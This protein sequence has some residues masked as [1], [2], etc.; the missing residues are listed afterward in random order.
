MGF[1]G[2]ASDKGPAC[3]CRDLR[4]SDLPEEVV[5]FLLGESHGQRKL[6]GCGP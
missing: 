6:A 1:P 3:Q 4:C 2:G 5:V